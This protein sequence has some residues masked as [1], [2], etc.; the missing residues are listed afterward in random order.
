MNYVPIEKMVC[1]YLPAI[2]EAETYKVIDTFLAKQKK[3]L[4]TKELLSNVTLIQGYNDLDMTITKNG[5][6][7]GYVITPRESKTIVSK[8]QQIGFI[9]DAAQTFTVYLFCTSQKSA[10]QSKSISIT[11]A[12]TLQWTTLDWEIYFDS[13]TYGAG[14]RYLI[15]YFEDALTANLYEMQW[16]GSQ[17]HIAQ[18]IFG[19]YMGIS[20]IRFTS[21]TL[22]GTYIPNQKYLHSAM[23]C[24]TPGFNLRF[25]TKCDITKVLVDNIDMFAQ[26]IQHQIAI[27]I[28]QDALSNIELN[29]VTSALSHRER[30]KE[31]LTEYTGKLNGGLME[32]VGYI[33]G[34]IDRLSIDFSHMDA[35]CLKHKSNEIT[36]VKW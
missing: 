16:T 35:I 30:W 23:N 7:V 22:N 36:S 32:G 9:S 18:Q 21:G 8:I 4:T 29:N 15:G 13:D 24:H 25:N 19:H 14:E 2:H 26:A 11:S 1:D 5:R 28:L 34:M 20:P 27:R 10:I 33:P 17:S 12:D 3:D 31:L 6:F